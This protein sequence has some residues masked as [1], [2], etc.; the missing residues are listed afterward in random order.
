MRI[1]V[2]WYKNAGV[3]GYA[4]AFRPVQSDSQTSEWYSYFENDV[5]D[6]KKACRNI[7]RVELICYIWLIN[8]CLIF[9]YKKLWNGS[10]SQSS[11]TTFIH[12]KN[13]LYY[14]LLPSRLYCRPRNLTGS[15]L[16]A[17]G[18][19]RREGISLC[20]EDIFLFILILY[21]LFVKQNFYFT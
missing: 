20:P 4:E 8:E 12:T 13:Q 16:S 14:H 11:D 19:Y 10:P 3:A 7:C 9:L 5:P 18:L 2:C 1:R 6:T 15:C 21:L 17:R